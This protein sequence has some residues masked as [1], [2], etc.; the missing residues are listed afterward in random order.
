MASIFRETQE[1]LKEIIIRDIKQLKE[2]PRDIVTTP[3]F[4]VVI[5]GHFNEFKTTALH[6]ACFRGFTPNVKILVEHGAPL[7][8]EDTKKRRPLHR[9]VGENKFEAAA[10]LLRAGADPNSGD[11]DLMT[12]LHLACDK[13]FEELARLLVEHKADVSARTEGGWTPLHYA[14]NS[15]SEYICRL[16]VSAGATV[17]IADRVGWSPLHAAASNGKV[18][19]VNFLIDREADLNPKDKDGRTP[20]HVSKPSAVATLITNGADPNILNNDAMNPLHSACK[21]GFSNVA[22]VL[23]SMGANVNLPDGEGQTP[24]E[25][26]IRSERKQYQD[27]LVCVLLD[28]GADCSSKE[29]KA[30]LREKT[31]LR[32][33]KAGLTTV[34]DAV[35]KHFKNV[36]SLDLSDNDI[37]TLPTWLADFKLESLRLNGNPLQS[38][39]AEVLDARHESDL[40]RSLQTYLQLLKN[41]TMG[42]S[43]IKLMLVGRECVGKT[44]LLKSFSRLLSGKEKQK[45]PKGKLLSTDGID[46]SELDVPDKFKK[47]NVDLK[48]LRFQCYDFGGQVIFYPTH[49]FFLTAH[50]IY[51]VCFNASTEDLSPI[52][53][54]LNQ[55]KASTH[56]VEVPVIIVGTHID[57][58]SVDRETLPYLAKKL[59]AMDG[60]V[61]EV[62]FVSTKTM[63]NVPELIE[64][65]IELASRHSFLKKQIPK[66]YYD[67]HE[68][69]IKLRPSPEGA[70]TGKTGTS[71]SSTNP[72]S[73]G[74]SGRGSG[75]TMQSQQSRT[76]SGSMVSGA[77]RVGSGAGTNQASPTSAAE[78]PKEVGRNY[79][80]WNDMVYL[81][82]KCGIEE[83]QLPEVVRFLHNVGAVIHFNDAFGDLSD[84]V[85]I[86]PQWLASVMKTVVS[87]SNTWCKNGMIS[88]GD[89]HSWVWREYPAHLHRN[90]QRIFEKFQ[91]VYP[92]RGEGNDDA[93]KGQDL[94]VPSLLP[95]TCPEQ[96]FE[97]HWPP[98]D[99]LQKQLGADVEIGVFARQ[100]EVEFVPLGVFSRL[101]VRALHVPHARLLVPWR[102]GYIVHLDKPAA[103]V[104]QERAL[105]RQL[106]V[107]GSASAGRF[108][109]I[110]RVAVK[111]STNPSFK[112]PR[113]VLLA[114]LTLAIDTLLQAYP[115]M[116]VKKLVPCLL[117]PQDSALASSTA[118]L[119]AGHVL[120]YAKCIEA[121]V[122]GQPIP[123]G[124]ALGRDLR[125]HEVAPDL[126]MGSVKV[127]ASDQLVV[128]KEVGRGGFGAVFKGTWQGRPV[129]IKQLHADLLDEKN[130]QKFD[131]FKQEVYL[132]NCLNQENIVRL[133]GISQQPLSMVMEFVP[134]GDLRHLLEPYLKAKVVCKHDFNQHAS[135]FRSQLQGRER[136]LAMDVAADDVVLIHKEEGPL[137]F[138]ETSRSERGLF[139]V[140][141]L[142]KRA[143]PLGDAQIPW[144]LRWKIALDIAKG[145]KYLHSFKPP[146]VHRDLRSPN[147]FMM[148]YDANEKVTA[149]VG[150]FGLARH[151]DPKLYEALGTWQWLAP[152][153]LR[154]D[155]EYDERSDIYSYGIV[156]YEIASRLTPFVDE[157]WFRFLRNNYF[158]KMDCIR[159]II[160]DGC[161]PTPPL[162]HLCPKEF[163]TLMKECWHDDPALRPSFAEIVERITRHLGQNDDDI[164]FNLS[165][166]PFGFSA[167]SST[168]LPSLGSSLA[169]PTVS[170]TAPTTSSL[171]SATS[172]TATAAATKN[173]SDSKQGEKE[174][175]KEKAKE[176]EKERE[177]EGARKREGGE[178]GGNGAKEEEAPKMFVWKDTI[179]RAP[180]PSVQCFLKV[181]NQ[182]WVGDGYG[183][184]ILYSH[185]SG[186]Q[187]DEF[188][189]ARKRAQINGL[190]AVDDT[191]WAAT[192]T[193]IRIYQLKKK[194]NKQEWKKVKTL[195][196]HKKLISGMLAVPD[197]S[198]GV[199][200]WT[201]D[202]AG[203]I[204]TWNTK[205]RKDERELIVKEDESIY[206]MCVVDNCS[207][208]IGGMTDLFRVNLQTWEMMHWRAHD[209]AITGIVWEPNQ[210][211]VWT[212][213]HDRKLK[214]WQQASGM[215][216]PGLV[217]CEIDVGRSYGISLSAPLVAS[218]PFVCVGHRDGTVSVWDAK[219]HRKLSEWQAHGNDVQAMQYV[220]DRK[221]N[222]AGYLWTGA[223]DGTLSVW[224]QNMRFRSV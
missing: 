10:I 125:V 94:M 167:T 87:F 65:L 170:T 41:S 70:A 13:G 21:K 146:I 152:E 210:K 68:A 204:L 202:I 213:S 188:Q 198:G 37:N 66:A 89:L 137:C 62:M 84:L 26:V 189:A 142:K 163:S 132:M 121:V 106:A 156:L 114:E 19:V 42:W 144:S 90:M 15:G 171:P 80:K 60:N 187:Q 28:G 58:P 32:L 44:S 99:V 95:E 168:S 161:R 48:S 29:I 105:V 201:C 108:E 148:N 3:D 218:Q 118:E 212:T 47:G 145:M 191:V 129:A 55:V 113:V 64:K 102:Y 150:D 206:S 81:G 176:K 6:E 77:S 1:Q 63:E 11:G 109:V 131:E 151:V 135:I 203:T 75:S 199:Q 162:P 101:M 177:G 184:A 36:R 128:E 86:N 103:G 83:E 216:S 53:Y 160:N 71:T 112:R 174:K 51:L 183:K 208:W 154:D 211:L 190:I 120:P 35:F 9:A 82:R 24:L 219:T 153:V 110:T 23:V 164:S 50:S 38:I 40:I 155:S 67:L 159:A 157:Y 192:D 52:H 2:L 61:R 73:S 130:Q 12:A 17:N 209:Q 200:V 57:H 85:I 224:A 133:Y 96:R 107:Q 54:W 49:Q 217:V 173:G 27:P 46:I 169:L 196:R 4:R 215:A 149:K 100:Y 143:Q 31:E 186:L 39:P 79:L 30:W 222:D 117:E 122:T 7:D 141:C 111:K 147:V 182:V 175:E 76:G 45:G 140:A 136:E 56:S 20:L 92:L 180:N 119:P 98:L 139:P 223:L 93:V 178:N 138:I 158:Q 185:I 193:L 74:L 33:V 104:V 165:P 181:D 197:L 172:A 179:R 5:Q 166:T 123:C 126:A 207:V 8:A 116:D 115:G 25:I 97:D 43:R 69:V 124:P 59:R 205:K 127:L 16:L 14:A 195:K 221:D 134:S 194:K 91:V 78:K 22:R 34:P 88:E 72:L 214:V 220:V 18:A